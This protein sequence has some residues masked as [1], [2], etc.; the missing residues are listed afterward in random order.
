MAKSRHNSPPPGYTESQDDAVATEQT[1]LLPGGNALPE[2]GAVEQP[3]PDD[4][5]IGNDGA[6]NGEEKPLPIF[7]ILVLSFAR[8]IEP[9]AFFSIFPYVNQMAQQNGNL[10]EEDVGFYSGLIESLFS[11]TQAVVMILWG[12]LADRIGRKPVLVTS[13][14]GMSL[15][16]SCFGLAKTIPQMILFR[17]VSGLFAGTVVTIRTMFAEHSTP[18]TQ[19]KAFTYF[20]FANNL[21]IFLG[22]LLGGALADPAGQY[23]GPFKRVPL[24]VEYPYFLASFVVGI[25][26]LGAWLVTLLFAE[27]TL[28][29]TPKPAA[30]SD[31]NGS[32]AVPEGNGTTASA[33]VAN[34]ISAVAR[35]VAASGEEKEDRSIMG[36]LKAPG[37]GIVAYVYMHTMVLAF[38]Y[39]AIIPVFYFTPVRLGGYG[40]TPILISTLSAVGGAAQ[41]L[42]LFALSPLQKRIGTNGIIRVCANF[43]PFFF[44]LPPLGNVLLRLGTQEAETAFWVLTPPLICLGVGVSLCF[45]AGTLAINEVSPSPQVLGTLNAL[46]LT[47][48]SIVRSFCPA[49][50]STLFAVGANTQWL[51]GYAIW[52]LLVV[53]AL[54]FTVAARY[55]PDYEELKLKREEAQREREREDRAWINHDTT[56]A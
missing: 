9:I 43:Y 18:A 51:W 26:G 29:K 11:L 21:G 35:I 8:L 20:A 54:G 30:S 5:A 47:G 32:V 34:P 42:W 1:P 53:L 28:V 19:A 16:I 49:L 13:L 41:A 6:A 56:E 4:N 36:I 46:V 33:A 27:E 3:Q 24:F 15:T 48:V 45:T 10:A 37:V 14:L 23:G 44:M 7:Q 22:P 38:A 55:L 17:C 2:T 31:T 25:L 40:M 39:T 50:F 52:V 12:R